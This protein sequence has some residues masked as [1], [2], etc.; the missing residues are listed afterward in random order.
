VQII[1]ICFSWCYCHPIISCSSKI[2]N[3]LLF[4]CQ[5][6]Q[7][8]LEKRPINWCISSVV[9][10]VILF[11]LNTAGL[12]CVECRSHRW[13]GRNMKRSRLHCLTG[14]SKPLTWC[15]TRT[16]QQLSTSW[17]F[18]CLYH[19]CLQCFDTVELGVRKSIRPVK[20]QVTRYWHG[21]LSG[22]SNKG[23][24]YG[25][26]DASATPS[27]MLNLSGAGLPRL[28]WQRGH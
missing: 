26:A 10:I 9:V 2:Q 25:L 15:L 24:A 20:Y 27:D 28:S 7:V 1:C 5:L 18:A 12:P 13:S 19:Y 14:C 3:G 22:V 11:N 17:R 6:T 21:Y 16:S 4:W 23:F 8:V